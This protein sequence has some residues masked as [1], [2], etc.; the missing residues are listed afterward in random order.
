MTGR[1][2]DSPIGVTQLTPHRWYDTTFGARAALAGF[3]VLSVLL[4]AAI[5][6]AVAS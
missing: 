2:R 5:I 1:Y 6:R 3:V 4:V